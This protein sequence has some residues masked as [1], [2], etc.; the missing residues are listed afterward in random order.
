[1]DKKISIL[2]PVYNEANTKK[3]CVENVLKSSEN[4]DMEIIISDNNSI[5]GT[6]DILKKISHPKITVF[7]REK[8]EGTGANLKNALKNATGEIIIFQDGDLEYSPD[9]YVELINP[10][11]KYFS[12]KKKASI[13]P[14]F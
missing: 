13:K 2:I 11:I 6:I 7:F 8:N 12:S 14:A 3:E 9:N 5:D 1:M 10:F 4:F